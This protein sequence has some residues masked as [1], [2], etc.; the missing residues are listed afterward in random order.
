MASCETVDLIGYMEGALEAEASGEVEEH[1][2]GCSNCRRSLEELGQ[3][4]EWLVELWSASGESC[5][6]AEAL[7]EYVAGEGEPAARTTVERHLERCPA[8][9]E[10]LGILQAFEAEWVPPT[11]GVELPE[12]LRGRLP[13]L[14]A[15]TLA[16]RLKRA[17]QVAMGRETA[18]GAEMAEWLKRILEPPA[19]TWPTAALPT[20]AAE[21]EEDDDEPEP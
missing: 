11:E 2:A 10:L 19:E 6:P 8:C 4:R 20:D 16:E 17:A 14:A 7:A 12:R 3:A 21:V 13:S 15:G 5:P 18:E 1:L 9:G